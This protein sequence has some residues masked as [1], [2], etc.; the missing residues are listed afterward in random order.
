MTGKCHVV[1]S[2][3]KVDE[4]ARMAGVSKATVDRVLNNR[5]GV[6]EHTRAH[7]MAIAASLAETPG[8]VSNPGKIGLD[9]ILAGGT[10][11][12][13][14]DL[15]LHLERQAAVRPDVDVIIHR[16]N[17]IEPEEIAE[18]LTSLR[19]SCK[20]VG[21]IGLDSPAVREALRQR[22]AA[23]VPVLTL[24]SDISHVGR[25]SYVGI[26]N[27]AAGR[28]AGY[29]IGRFVPGARGKIAL[30]AGALAYRGHEERE[31]GFRHVLDERFPLLEIIA[32]R[33]VKENPERAYSE[34]R[35]LLAEEPELVAIY[36][37][38]A[39]HAGIARALKE[40]GREKSL[41]FVGHD[42][43]DDTRQYLLSGVMDAV[44]D[45]NA[46][47]EAREAIDRL[48]RATRNETSIS[49]ATI[50]IQSVFSENIPAD[51]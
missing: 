22:I 34:V 7:V 12:F 32:V 10:N 19:P 30:I 20:G 28:L 23:G 24:V 3:P 31:M 9:F 29:L 43:T 40:A 26:D 13:I 39:G 17:G 45:Q 16:L 18:K 48:V 14:A 47:V 25:V 6:Q 5:P 4:I 41:I 46:G 1:K 50:R 44:I 8:E 33:E 11:P 38:G 2:R 27:R 15:A 37:I 36:C 51:A 42:L 49:A 21:L 35:T